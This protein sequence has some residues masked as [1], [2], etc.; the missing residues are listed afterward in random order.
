[1]ESHPEGELYHGR[2][3]AMLEALWG[4]GFLSPGGAAEIARLIA[5]ADLNRASLLDIGCG[6]GGADI[7]LV[8]EHG[9]GFVTGIDVED[10]VLASARALIAREGLARQIGLAKVAP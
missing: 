1:M 6:A 4:E 2:A 8:R 7:A 9:A 3:V 5:D 10:T